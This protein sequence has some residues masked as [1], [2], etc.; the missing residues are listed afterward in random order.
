MKVLFIICYY[1]RPVMAR[2][3]ITS[4]LSANILHEDW[5]LA[6]ID[7]GSFPATNHGIHVAGPALELLDNKKTFIYI[8]DSPE[9]KILQGGSRHG[10]YINKAILASDAD[11]AVVCCDDDAILPDYFS[12]LV[13]WFSENPDK[14]YCYSHVRYYNP[15][16]E[17][18]FGIE[19]R[20]WW[21]NHTR[22]LNPDNSVDS[23]QVA[24]RTSCFKSDGIRY[25]SPQTVNLDSALFK[26]FF[27][28]YGPCHYT[29]FDGQYKGV[30]DQQMGSRKDLYTGTID[31]T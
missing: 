11:I 26:Q 2:N 31:K 18:P 21:T 14:M 15:I 20:P 16:T 28:K 9:Q 1:N 19:K 12:N 7:D 23:S 5:E 4:L 3:A 25:P 27:N 10:E 22:P 13:K 17:S 8:D 30:F 6:F 29:G 24:F